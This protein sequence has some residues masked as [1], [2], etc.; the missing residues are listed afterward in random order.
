MSDKLMGDMVWKSFCQIVV[1]KLGSEIAPED[2]IDLARMLDP[3][4]VFSVDELR[5]W[6]RKNM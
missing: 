6:A 1:Q 5:D 3:G 2:V 4:E